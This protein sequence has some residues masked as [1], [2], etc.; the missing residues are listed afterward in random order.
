M[1]FSSFVLDTEPERSNKR[2]AFASHSANTENTERRS[3]REEHAE[4]QDTASHTRSLSRRRFRFAE[5]LLVDGLVKL[6]SSVFRQER[7]DF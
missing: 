6:R 7:N 4:S 5:Q 1:D 3:L 2:T